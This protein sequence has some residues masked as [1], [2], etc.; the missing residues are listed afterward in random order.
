MTEEP[1]ESSNANQT[2]LGNNKVLVWIIKILCTYLK[3]C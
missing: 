2:N 1:V 3:F